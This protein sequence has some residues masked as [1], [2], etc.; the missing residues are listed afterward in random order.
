MPS[1]A[2]TGML[3]SCSRAADALAHGVCATIAAMLGEPY[4]DVLGASP[5]REAPVDGL[6]QRVAQAHHLPP[7]D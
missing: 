7:Y 5:R 4:P 3:W 1:G 2:A 6:I